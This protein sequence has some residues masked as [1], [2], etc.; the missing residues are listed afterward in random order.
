M[1]D[2]QTAL[3][4]ANLP[5]LW[6]ALEQGSVVVFEENRVRIRLLPIGRQQRQN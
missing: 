6:D 4:I 3:L 1:P 2:T 5:N